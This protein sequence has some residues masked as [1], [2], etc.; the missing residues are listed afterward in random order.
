MRSFSKLKLL[1]HYLRSAVVQSRL[2][3][4]ALLSIEREVADT[5]NFDIVINDFV[6]V[7]SRSESR[8]VP[9]M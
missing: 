8:S 4:L 9:E 2:S 6:F 1:K 3:D 7:K 5:T